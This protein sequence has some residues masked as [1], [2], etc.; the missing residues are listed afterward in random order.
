ML[1]TSVH[2]A[3]VGTGDTGTT[4]DSS[5]PGRSALVQSRFLQHATAGG[6]LVGLREGEGLGLSP[7]AGVLFGGGSPLS[8]ANA[9]KVR[10]FSVGSKGS[11]LASK[12]LQDSRA[13]QNG[14]P[15]RQVKHGLLGP[16]PSGSSVTA[17]FGQRD[18][19]GS[20]AVVGSSLGSG[21]V[22]GQQAGHMRNM[23]TGP[24]INNPAPP[25]NISGH[26]I[27][28]SPCNGCSGANQWYASAAVASV[29]AQGF[30]TLGPCGLGPIL[31]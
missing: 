23:S 15:S 31:G 14:V 13:S 7:T 6:R 30:P 22:S 9:H 18:T 28:P 20:A 26:P 4:A 17:M 1:A 25:G 29:Q 21:S 10:A 8:E 3:L 5:G 27:A 16:V 2:T 19:S 12:S 11:I 24:A